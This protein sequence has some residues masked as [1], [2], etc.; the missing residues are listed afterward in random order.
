MRCREF[1]DQIA[2]L[3]LGKLMQSAIPEHSETCP[4]CAAWLEKQRNLA[5]SLQA[6]RVQTSGHEA[7]P[8]VERALVRVFRQGV[9]AGVLRPATAAVS[10]ETPAATETRTNDDLR[11]E[12]VSVSTPFAWRLSRLFEIG[13]Y[14]AATA[15]IAVAI[16]LGLQ[17]AHR[18]GKNAPVQ[19][20]ALP[21]QTV[22]AT[23]EPVATASGGAASTSS[24]ETPHGAASRRQ[25]SST[26]AAVTGSAATSGEESQ[27]NS[28]ADYM[29]LMICDPLSCSTETQV[30][31]MELPG[32]ASAEPQ[33]A[34][35]VVGYDGVV[36]AVR[37]VN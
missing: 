21:Q 9:S 26:P 6:L 22:P 4:A 19:S 13:A 1:K 12:P 27:A 8:D 33:L 31:R 16:F 7:G 14:V 3:G 5:A 10:D 37:F 23:Q 18:T 24:T 34:D 17:L 25:R 20:Q 32:S 29:A 15:A 28:D 2:S 35:V 30:V 36:R 11:L